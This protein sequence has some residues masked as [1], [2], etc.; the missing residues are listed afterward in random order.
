MKRVGHTGFWLKQTKAILLER[1]KKHTEREREREREL[2]YCEF[3]R[4]SKKHREIFSHLKCS[5][6]EE[7]E[8]YTVR[9]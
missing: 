2:K 9:V 8:R 3:H 1:E 4:V 7:I 6:K 5:P